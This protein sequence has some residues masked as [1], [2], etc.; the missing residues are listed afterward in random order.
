MTVSP[1]LPAALFA[2]ALVL[3]GRRAL[4]LLFAGLAAVLV[5]VFVAFFAIAHSLFK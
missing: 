4:L 3:F 2:F 1:A 5:V